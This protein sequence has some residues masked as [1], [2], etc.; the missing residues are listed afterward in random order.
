[1]S[2]VWFIFLPILHV[3][4]SLISQFC[5]SQEQNKCFDETFVNIYFFLN[6]VSCMIFNI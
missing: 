1:M 2:G 6:F 4:K 3:G 5:G